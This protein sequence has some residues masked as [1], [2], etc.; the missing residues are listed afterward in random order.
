MTIDDFEL[1]RFSISIWRKT[2]NKPDDYYA[3]IIET[4]ST[5]VNKDSRLIDG[6]CHVLDSDAVRYYYNYKLHRT[7]GPAV[8][9]YDGGKTWC[10][11]GFIHRDDKPAIINANGDQYW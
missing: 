3:G 2:F 7:D 9:F 8:E 4:M 6:Y 5:E 10:Q 11:N 1:L